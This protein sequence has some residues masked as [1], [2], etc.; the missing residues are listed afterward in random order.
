MDN[1]TVAMT[2]HQPTPSSGKTAMGTD[3]KIIR[4]QDVAKGLGIEKV[5]IV[6]PY[7]IKATIRSN[8]RKYLIIMVHQLLSLR[9]HVH[10]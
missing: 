2:G 7:D 9:S 10:F 5:D 3:A 1:S 4:I 6:D 8:K